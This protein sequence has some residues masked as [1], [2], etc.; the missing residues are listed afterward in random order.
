M[1]VPGAKPDWALRVLCAMIVLLA[2]AFDPWS[3]DV[4]QLPKAAILRIGTLVALA[5]F[6]RAKGTWSSLRPSR[7][8]A[9]VPAW[10]GVCAFFTVFSLQPSVS[11]FGR[12]QMFIWGFWTLASLAVLYGVVARMD[13]ARTARALFLTACAAG[14]LTLILGF[15]KTQ[16]GRPSS[17]LGS[18][19]NYSGWLAMTAPLWLCAALFAQKKWNRR[20]STLALALCAYQLL[21]TLGRGAWLGALAGMGLWLFL[22]RRAISNRRNAWTWVLALVLAGS[23]VAVV[24]RGEAVRERMKV[25][26]SPSEQSAGTR[27]ELWG[28]A[29]RMALDARFWGRGLD[30][31]GLISPRYE[32]AQMRQRA[33][34]LFITTYAHNEFLQILV[35][36]GLPGLLAY[37][38]LW[39]SWTRR[40]LRRI[41]S[42]E[43]TDRPLFSALFCSAL[44]L[45]V[46]SQFNFP[47]IATLALQW[48]F[49]GTLCGAGIAATAPPTDRPAAP[50]RAWLFVLPLLLLAV[51]RSAADRIADKLAYKARVLLERRDP[52]RALRYAQLAW[53][54]NP[55]A[56]AYAMTLSNALYRH[57]MAAARPE[58]KVRE[59]STA[60]EVTRRDTQLHPYAADAWHNHAM[61]MMWSAL[62]LRQTLSRLKT[63]SPEGEQAWRSLAKKAESAELRAVEIAPTISNFSNSLGEIRHFSQDIPGAK[64]AWLEAVRVN[65]ADRKANGWLEQYA[66][67]DVFMAAPQELLLQGLDAGKGID[68]RAAGKSLLKV[69]NLREQDLHME[70]TRAYHWNSLMECPQDARE[71]P[72]GAPLSIESPS[73]ILRPNEVKT[74]SLGL[75]PRKGRSCYIL[76]V[77]CTDFEV[78]V[79]RMVTVITETEA[80]P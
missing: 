13:S 68:L 57:G 43:E 6:L 33:G 30:T 64:K 42:C 77:R 31:F 17:T 41:G 49:L 10:L 27:L 76:R 79:D 72:E 75:T 46:H 22:N 2:L 60:I 24:F 69:A 44:A 54:I 67:E 14:A 1:Q 50:N 45:W 63:A 70:V 55:R 19:L 71:A 12:D 74:I 21:A 36:L 58:D 59:L 38:W 15:I 3:M 25:F 62:E 29:G 78:P 4:Y 80:R 35:T 20:L 52:G 26:L 32:S 8:D 18:A 7:E 28:M 9:P 11:F 65:P 23:A 47:S 5:L 39:A 37:L 61:S 53:R 16:G 73:F 56:E 40:A 48:A 34:N 66:E 51:G